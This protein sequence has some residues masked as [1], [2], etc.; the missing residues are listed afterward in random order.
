[1]CVLLQGVKHNHGGLAFPHCAALLSGPCAHHVQ[2][3]ATLRTGD[4]F[5]G[6]AAVYGSGPLQA[7]LRVVAC[8]WGCELVHAHMAGLQQHGGPQLIK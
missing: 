2:A 3:V 7:A 5:G 8:G 1:M 4:W 6:G